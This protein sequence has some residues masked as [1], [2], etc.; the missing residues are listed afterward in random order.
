MGSYKHYLFGHDLAKVSIL[1]AA[2]DNSIDFMP[3]YVL[4]YIFDEDELSARSSSSSSSSSN[5]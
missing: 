5:S 3:L 2:N 4:N 1:E